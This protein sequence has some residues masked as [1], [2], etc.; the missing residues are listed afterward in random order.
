MDGASLTAW[1]WPANV[2]TAR[3]V[4]AYMHRS[5]PH[6]HEWYGKGWV[7]IA[8]MAIGGQAYS[9]WAQ[10]RSKMPENSNYAYVLRGPDGED[11][12]WTLRSGSVWDAPAVPK[13]ALVKARVQT[14]DRH[15]FRDL[16]ASCH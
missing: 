9:L 6:S 12:P 7:E 5:L 8:T 10:S 3:D 1:A 14:H 15:R 16:G 11:V 2:K 4:A 13:A